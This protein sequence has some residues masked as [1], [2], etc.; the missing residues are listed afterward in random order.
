MKMSERLPF[1]DRLDRAGKFF[2]RSLSLLLWGFLLL[3]LGVVAGLLMGG[4]W[5]L[6]A[7]V[8]AFL[9]VVNLIFSS[10]FFKIAMRWR[11]QRNGGSR[12]HQDTR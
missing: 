9:G 1:G 4:G 2:D 8:T 6:V 11:F 3:G 12:Q 10:I 7:I 5:R